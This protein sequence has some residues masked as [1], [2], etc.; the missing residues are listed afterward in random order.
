MN[1]GDVAGYISL[2]MQY[3]AVTFE[4]NADGIKTYRVTGAQNFDCDT[5]Y[6]DEVKNEVKDFTI[7][8]S[9]EV[10]V[11]YTVTQTGTVDHY[12]LGLPVKNA[13]VEEVTI[14]ISADGVKYS[15]SITIEAKAGRWVGIKNGMFI[16]HDSTVKADAGSMRVEYVKYTE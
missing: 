2:G 13:P 5:P 10:Y 1:E 9:G 15:N 11:K 16:R 6:T 4:K 12:E 7:G 8:T 14:E 3:C